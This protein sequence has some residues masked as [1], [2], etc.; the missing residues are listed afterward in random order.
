MKTI[1]LKKSCATLLAALVLGGAAY[2]GSQ[3]ATPAARPQAT[4]EASRLVRTRSR[5]PWLGPGETGEASIQL[6]KCLVPSRQQP[7]KVVECRGPMMGGYP[8]Q[9]FDI[10]GPGEYTGRARLQHVLQYRLRVDDELELVY[11][12]TREETKRPY[13]LNVGDEIRLEMSNDDLIARTLIVQPDGTVSLPYLG[14]FR[15]TRYTISEL[16]RVLEERY[17][18]YYRNMEKAITITP[19]KINSKLEDLRASVDSRAGAGGQGRRARVT[20]EGTIALPAVG[21]IPAQ[22][23]TLEEL[24]LE[25]DARYA[26]EIEGI[27]V[28]PVLVQRAPRY[29]FVLGEVRIPGRFSL[30]GPTTVMQAIAMAGS[31]TVGA[32]IDQVVI[33]RR[34][35]DWRLIATMLDLRQALLGRQPCPAGEIWLSDA[36]LIIVPK[37]KVLLTNNFI[38]LVFTRGIYGVIPFSTSVGFT[39]LTT[40]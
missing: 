4:Q 22:G 17:S 8:S 36:D 32:N 37:S 6:C 24:K 39:N 5:A 14:Q 27:E 19:L 30:E 34:T 13:H 28:T 33:L 15:V 23:L 10:Y 25:L 31:W 12:L 2:C 29:V 40:F 18:E 26:V 3:E 16:T 7:N 38:E 35:E 21:S 20:P 9:P 11:R 1:N